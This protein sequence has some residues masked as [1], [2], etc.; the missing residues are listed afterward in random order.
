LPGCAEV[1]RYA[2]AEPSD[3]QD[4]QGEPVAI[5]H[6][7]A[8]GSD[9]MARFGRQVG[10]ANDAETAGRIDAEFDLPALSQFG[11]DRFIAGEIRDR[12]LIG[13]SAFSRAA[14]SACERA[15]FRLGMRGEAHAKQETRDEQCSHGE[16]DATQHS[17]VRA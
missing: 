1:Q 10:G 16:L 6:R 14:E 5:V 2:V 13:G 17:W 7:F 11:T 4:R 9:D 3:H 12:L 15:I 8:V